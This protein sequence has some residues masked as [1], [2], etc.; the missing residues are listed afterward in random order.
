VD[1]RPWPPFTRI[2]SSSL[3]NTAPHLL[4]RTNLEWL[5]LSKGRFQKTGSYF[6]IIIGLVAI[7]QA[8]IHTSI[9]F[10]APRVAHLAMAS[11]NPETNT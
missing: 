4:T 10:V 11:K 1:R 7:R 2:Q 3:F 8:A 6:N 5:C 9:L